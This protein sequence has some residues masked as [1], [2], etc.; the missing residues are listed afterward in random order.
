M[1][2]KK[3]TFLDFFSRNLFFLEKKIDVGGTKN[4][5]IMLR[6][7]EIKVIFELSIQIPLK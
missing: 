5:T 7:F 1:T 4:L 2:T 6:F 3:E